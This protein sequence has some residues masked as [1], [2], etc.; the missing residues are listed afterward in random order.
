MWNLCSTCVETCARS[1]DACTEPVWSLW[2][3]VYSLH[4][5]HGCLHRACVEAMGFSV[6]PVWSL[7]KPVWSRRGTCG[8]FLF[9]RVQ[10]QSQLLS[11]GQARGVLAG[12][13]V[14]IP[15]SPA[16]AGLL[17][18]YPVGIF[19]IIFPLNLINPHPVMNLEISIKHTITNQCRAGRWWLLAVCWCFVWLYCFICSGRGIIPP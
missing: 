4:G 18:M 14:F 15:P 3:Y 10:Q 12:P 19:F 1:V 7:W 5:D 16:T 17:F 13:Y 11:R 6:A 9:C 8:P 2:M